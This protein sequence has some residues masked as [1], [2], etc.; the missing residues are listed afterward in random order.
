M[1]E[2]KCPKCGKAMEDKAKE[3]KL[4]YSFERCVRVCENCGC[5]ASNAKSNPTYIYKNYINNL[6]DK[7]DK[8][9]LDVLFNH[10]LNEKNREDKKIKFGFST[11]EDACSWIFFTYFF[12]K[13]KLD[14]LK[15]VLGLKSE[16][17]DI[18]FWGVSYNDLINSKISEISDGILE[19]NNIIK[20]LKQ[21]E[22]NIGEISRLRTE[23]D[24]IIV[25][26]EE[27]V[28]VEV[29]VNSGMPT[30]NFN[31]EKNKENFE[32]Y[33]NVKYYNNFDIIGKKYKGSINPFYELVR[34]WTLLNDLG[35][36]LNKKVCLI[37]LVKKE[38]TEE[39][40]VFK[41]A[42]NE[43]DKRI[44]KV[45]TWEEI[46]KD[47]EKKHNINISDDCFKNLRDNNCYKLK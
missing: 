31:K 6:P 46:F 28:F 4:A 9:M 2:I 23:P 41:K 35:G 32:K 5:G 34:N 18:L 45:R 8:D 13:N 16:I 20:N 42:I 29:K 24:I 36:K 1:N 33:S 40:K 37:N 15:D 12:K 38:E 26:D 39:I 3:K 21:S 10:T 22:D 47:L 14:V 17:K 27:L 44:F 19:N 43:S 30:F 25:T 7:K 11:S